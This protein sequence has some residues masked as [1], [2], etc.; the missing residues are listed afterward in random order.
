MY[1]ACLFKGY[2]LI[3][4][5]RAGRSKCVIDMQ[6][7]S[8]CLL[9]VTIKISFSRTNVTVSGGNSPIN[10]SRNSQPSPLVLIRRGCNLVCIGLFLISNQIT[11]PLFCTYV[12]FSS[13]SSSINISRNP[14]HSPSPSSPMTLIGNVEILLVLSPSS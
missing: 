13:G 9:Q 1:V 8:Q 12:S 2:S 4:S 14:L 7:C 6:F 10:M 11:N 3:Y 5:L